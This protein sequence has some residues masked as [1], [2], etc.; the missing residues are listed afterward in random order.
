VYSHK[1]LS[2]RAQIQWCVLPEL[3]YGPERAVNTK[4]VVQD[5]RY[6]RAAGATVDGVIGW[7]LLRRNSFRLDFANKGVVFEPISPS[8]RRAAFSSISGKLAM[9]DRAD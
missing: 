9:P 4:V 8:C 6:L 3:V 5:L 7:D 1:R 2:A